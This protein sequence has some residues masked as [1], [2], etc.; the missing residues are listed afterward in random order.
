MT[1]MFV[2]TR[3]YRGYYLSLASYH[4]LSPNRQL[5][6]LGIQGSGLIFSEPVR[7]LRRAWST[8]AAESVANAAGMVEE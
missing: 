6:R 2:T 3:D 5:K 8:Y 4:P 7:R 1:I